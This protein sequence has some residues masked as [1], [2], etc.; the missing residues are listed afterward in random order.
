MGVLSIA[1]MT[2]LFV[3]H[4]RLHWPDAKTDFHQ[5]IGVFSTKKNI[6]LKV[7]VLVLHTTVSHCTHLLY[8]SKDPSLTF[9]DIA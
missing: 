9:R 4:L 7:G 6:G 3:I 1:H 2:N 8:L 5:M